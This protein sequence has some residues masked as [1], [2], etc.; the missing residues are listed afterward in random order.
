MHW[1]PN[2]ALQYKSPWCAGE[3]EKKQ[4]LQKTIITGWKWFIWIVGW[5]SNQVNEEQIRRLF[6]S[7]WGMFVHPEFFGGKLQMKTLLT[8]E[9]WILAAIWWLGLA[10]TAR[11]STCRPP[12]PANASVGCAPSILVDVALLG[13]IKVA[14]TVERQ[15][16]K[17]EWENVKR[18]T[19]QAANTGNHRRRSLSTLLCHHTHLGDRGANS[20]SDVAFWLKWTN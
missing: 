1:S 16:G 12:L 8:L 19:C 17:R 11:W 18:V 15:S 7:T 6:R 20:E 3:G 13:L 5:K 10:E 2:A 14:P 9:W 4:Q